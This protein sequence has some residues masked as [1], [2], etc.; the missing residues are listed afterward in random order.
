MSKSKQKIVFKKSKWG[1]FNQEK[2][3]NKKEHF[4]VI[5]HINLF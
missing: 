2:N 5:D 4:N 3:W 1:F